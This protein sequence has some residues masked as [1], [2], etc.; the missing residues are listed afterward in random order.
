MIARLEEVAV[1]D[2]E[3]RVEGMQFDSRERRIQQWREKKEDQEFDRLIAKLKQKKKYRAWYDR[4]KNEPDFR[5]RLQEQCRVM[6]IKHGA[7]RNAESKAKRLAEKKPISCK[8]VEC[9]KPFENFGHKA[10]PSKFCSR[11][12]R[13]R[14]A[15]KRRDKK[16]ISRKDEV[17]ALLKARYSVTAKEAE[18]QLNMSLATVRALLNVLVNNGEAK[19]Y[20]D[21]IPFRYSIW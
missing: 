4:H 7:R 13:N 12:C 10:K 16:R 6:R 19:K 14:E 5:A 1:Y 20:K 8:C 17:M 2:D 11:T 21:E 9:G 15:H 3:G 18:A